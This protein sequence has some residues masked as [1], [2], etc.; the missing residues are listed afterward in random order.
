MLTE[1]L[2]GAAGA[3][4]ILLFVFG[5][6]PA[7]AMPLL[8]ASSSILTTFLCVY[9]LTYLTDVSIIVQ[10]LVALVGLGVAI[11]Y[12]LLMIFRFREELSH[13][14]TTEEAIVADDDPRR[15]IG[16]RLRLDGG[17]RPAQ[18]GAPAAAVHP[19]DRHRR[20]AD[21]GRLG[22]RVDHAACRPCCRCSG[23][24]STASA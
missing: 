17:D 12:A 15:T 9:G 7:V 13:G 16:D 21:P 20:H 5:T 24:A 3:L 22:A 2:L 1:T 8:I 11:D 23:R 6:L 10:F 18:H 19:L 14:E 4:I